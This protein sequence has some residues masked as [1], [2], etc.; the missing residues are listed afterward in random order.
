MCFESMSANA[1]K[2]QYTLD[3][4]LVNHVRLLSMQVTASEDMSNLSL[5]K[6]AKCYK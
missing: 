1:L 2:A 4:R 5:T 3:P 6:Q